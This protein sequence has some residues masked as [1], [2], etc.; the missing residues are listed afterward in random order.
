MW[1]SMG[2]ESQSVHSPRELHTQNS[3]QEPLL[4]PG[5]EQE[6]LLFQSV[7]MSGFNRKPPPV[8][9]SSAQNLPAYITQRNAPLAAN[10]VAENWRTIVDPAC[11]HRSLCTLEHGDD[12]HLNIEVLLTVAVHAVIL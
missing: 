3:A 5:S 7:D 9:S 4:A 8:R 1:A 10:P 11:E 6:S 12:V 2:S